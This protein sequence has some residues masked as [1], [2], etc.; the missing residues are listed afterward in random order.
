MKQSAGLILDLHSASIATWTNGTEESA[1]FGIAAGTF[2]EGLPGRSAASRL[3]SSLPCCSEF[4]CLALRT[5]WRVPAHLRVPCCTCQCPGEVFKEVY[6]RWVSAVADGESSR[7]HM[8]AAL[9]WTRMTLGQ[10][11]RLITR[12]TS[13]TSPPPS[14]NKTRNP[15]LHGPSVGPQ[16][17]QHPPPNNPRKRQAISVKGSGAFAQ[18]RQPSVATHKTWS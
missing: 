15:N 10:Q 9:A 3:M 6:T 4:C 13:T 14:R 2:V 16:K 11:P 18:A 17:L 8:L 5:V 1:I 12:H 7:S